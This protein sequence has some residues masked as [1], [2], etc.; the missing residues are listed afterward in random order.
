MAHCRTAA[1]HAPA[2]AEDAPAPGHYAPALLSANLL[3]SACRP[4]VQ[5]TRAALSLAH[6]RHLTPPRR[7]RRSGCRRTSAL[8][9]GHR[10]ARPVAQLEA[11]PAEHQD[12]PGAAHPLPRQAERGRHDA[13]R[14]AASAPANP[15]P[16]PNPNPNLNPDLNPD[17]D[18]NPT[19]RPKPN[20]DQVHRLAPLYLAL[21]K[22]VP[23]LLKELLRAWSVGGSKETCLLAFAGIRQLAAEMPPPFI[24]TCLK[25]T[26][27]A[28]AQACA[29]PP[30]HTRAPCTP[31]TPC[32]ACTA[33][34]PCIYSG[35]DDDCTGH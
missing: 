8:Q 10:A 4:R 35:N 34:I 14:A 20:P 33:C 27:L 31:C 6:G 26:Y 1:A 32:T 30:T 7:R 23:R 24:D 18:P 5:P 12:V 28:F 25:G 11:A 9:V 22:L 15:N 3:L 21:P 19:S 16:D 2:Q 29:P 13:R 17:P